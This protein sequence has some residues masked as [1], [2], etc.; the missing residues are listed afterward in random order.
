MTPALQPARWISSQRGGPSNQAAPYSSGINMPGNQ[1]R[2]IAVGRVRF[3]L[4]EVLNI[5]GNQHRWTGR[6][7][8]YGSSVVVLRQGEC[9]VPSGGKEPCASSAIEL[10]SQSLGTLDIREASIRVRSEQKGDQ[11][12]GFAVRGTHASWPK[13]KESV[14]EKS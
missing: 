12:S 14:N 3:H 11:P 9:V 1:I 4:V 10:R 5:L 2:S 8:R 6:I 13:R 7:I